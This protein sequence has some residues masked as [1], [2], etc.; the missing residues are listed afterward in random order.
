MWSM[1]T[2]PDQFAAWYGPDG[3]TVT[4]AEMD[5]RPGGRRRITMAMTT[6]DGV[7]EMWFAGEHQ[8]VDPDRRL[9]YT[10]VMVDAD[11]NETSPSTVVEITL[12]AL[13]GTTRMVLTH[14][15]IPADS[16]GAAGW[17]MALDK[18]VEAL[19]TR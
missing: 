16:P 6:P 4:V 11:G 14:R 7:H 15:G 1:W 12:E 5:V 17:S 2:E 8:V 9:V 13:G 18:L 3:V 19:R 10:E